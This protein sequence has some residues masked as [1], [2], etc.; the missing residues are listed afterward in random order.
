[1]IWQSKCIQCVHIFS[2]FKTDQKRLFQFIPHPVPAC[3]TSRQLYSCKRCSRTRILLLKTVSVLHTS[4]VDQFLL[5]LLQLHK[6]QPAATVWWNISLTAS[7][8]KQRYRGPDASNRAVTAASWLERRCL[9]CE[10]WGGGADWK[11]CCGL[12]DVSVSRRILKTLF[13][14]QAFSTWRLN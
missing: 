11:R 13:M 3:V 6:E 7:G 9:M 5:L 8:S 14:S 10:S 2:Y 4:L 12:W 1:M